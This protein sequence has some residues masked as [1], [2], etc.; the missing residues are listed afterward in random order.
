MS[1][2]RIIILVGAAGAAIGAAILVRSMSAAPAPVTNTVF[3]NQTS[4]LDRE[5]SEVQVLVA[6]RDLAIG[7][8]LAS[9]D[10]E[11]AP[12]P[13]KNVVEGYSTESDAPDAMETLAG[14]V[15][16]TPIYEREPVLPQKLVLK[17][18]TGLMAALLK[19]GMRA[20]SLEISEESASGGFILP[21]DYVDVILTH[22]QKVQTENAIRDV[23]ISTTIMKNVRVLAI[24]QIFKQDEDGVSSQIGNTA[25]L[26]VTSKEAELVALS[27]RIGTIS[28][29]LRPW[30]DASEAI[31]RESRVDLLE[32]GGSGG[33]VTIIRN[34]KA[35]SGLGGS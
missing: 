18:E 35:Q 23:P 7:A 14:S 9:D 12:W 31:A 6:K 34:G 32:A 15:V 30:S 10:L 29:S 27:S 19:P 33:G 13:E 1:P 24:D 11:W 4:F 21:N 16:K 17:G 26:E 8:V 3:E 22:E 2:M 25:T 5:V 28:L 20:V